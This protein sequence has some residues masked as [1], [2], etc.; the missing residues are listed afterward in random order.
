MFRR[1]FGTNLNEAPKEKLKK[2]YY[3]V[4]ALKN[5]SE[6]LLHKDLLEFKSVRLHTVINKDSKPSNL[7]I[8]EIKLNL[9]KW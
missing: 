5:W 8:V 7:S 4:F 3:K 1:I 6:L 2:K 9:R